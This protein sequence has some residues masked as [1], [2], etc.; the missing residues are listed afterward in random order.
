MPPMPYAPQGQPYAAPAY[1]A[2]PA[3]PLPTGTLDEFFD[4]PSGGKGPS[5]KFKDKPIG[6][7]YTGV[8]ARPVTNADIEVQTNPN[9]KQVVTF[10]DGRA[11]FQM[12]VPM[13]FPPTA[14]HP[15]GQAGW[16]VKGQARDELARAMAEAGAPAGPPEAGATIRVTLM[17]IRPIPNM[18]P[19]FI[20]RVEYYRPQ[21]SVPAVPTPE[22]IQTAPVVQQF[23]VAVQPM[24][25]VP[26]QFP[27][28]VVT[29]PAQPVQLYPMQQ[30]MAQP[31]PG[32]AVTA[33]PPQPYQVAT[34]QTGTAPQQVPLAPNTGSNAAPGPHLMPPGLDPEQQALFARLTGQQA[35]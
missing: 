22:P 19:Q 35:A 1:P 25:Q 17:Q 32:I 13:V 21:G 26:Q 4:Q 5:W 24:P 31:A 8:V 6:T 18:S 29:A 30:T 15:D 7:S 2:P 14:E 9:T 23:P 10:K 12:V 34:V 16:Y 20:Y 3:P 27:Q 28:P 11:K 33:A